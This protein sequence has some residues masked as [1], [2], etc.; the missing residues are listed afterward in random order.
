MYKKTSLYELHKEAGGKMVSFADFILPVEYSG[1][2]KEHMAVREKA[3]LFDVSHM[4]EFVLTGSD[5][6]NNLNYMFTNDFTNMTNGRVRYSPICNENGGIVDD[7][8]IYKIEEEKYLI[9]PNA[10]NKEK[11]YK[12]MRKHLQGDAK[13]ED[14]SDRISQFALQGPKAK[15]ILQR[16]ISKENI[17]DKYYTFISDVKVSGI[18]CLVSQTGYTGE[19]GYELYC[20]NDNAPALWETLLKSGEESGL[21]PCGLGAR[22]TLRLEAAMPLY[23]HEMNDN[24]TPLEAG[25]NF[26]VK[27]QKEDFLGKKAIE[28]KG[29]PQITRVGIKVTGRGIAREHNSV[30]IGDE[31]IGET[32]SGTYCPY[33]NGAYAMAFVNKT[34]A[35]IG[36]RIQIEVRGRKIDAEIAA[37]PFYKRS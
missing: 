23:G 30:Y 1:V 10:S 6:L 29:E 11:D 27:M 31:K 20:A 26:T 21:I 4:G 15:E 32:T 7:L 17:P 19:L 35:E 25:L 8:L 34:K 18:E 5:A 33:L 28:A 13:L 9:I 14:I 3:G 37:L 22:D 2:I 24:I 12:F 16:I 36:T